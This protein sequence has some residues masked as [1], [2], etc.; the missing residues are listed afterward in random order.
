MTEAITSNSMIPA[1]PGI[2]AAQIAAGAQVIAP[3]V[4]VTPPI[5]AP[6][7]TPVPAV[8]AYDFWGGVEQ[9]GEPEQIPAQPAGAPVAPVAPGVSPTAGQPTVP[10]ATALTPE[11]HAAI[12]E[13]D[14]KGAPVAVPA[15]AQ[16]PQQVDGLMQQTIAHLAQTEYAM[17]K[18]VA[19]KLVSNPEEVYPTLA[20]TMHVRLASQIGQAV[21]TLLPSIVEKI[22]SAKLEANRLENDFFRLYPLL[23]DPR[24][25]SVVA[26]SLSM[27]RQA[28]PQ[29]P[30]EQ[31]M[32]D[33]ASL[34][35]LKLRIAPQGVAPAQVVVP[36]APLSPA[37]IPVQQPL[38]APVAPLA[39]VPF[40]PAAG[41]GG[42]LPNLAPGL[43]NEFEALALDQNW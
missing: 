18:E 27:A 37:P 7:T 12:I 34:A 25:R 10:V 21:S 32:N 1:N 38:V 6:V 28:N 33:G 3:T 24:F 29:A 40:Q 42:A 31:V 5:V 9:R 17:P 8:E 16:A 41:G 36:G 35:A 2:A 13:A 11:Q 39:V 14:A 15:P 43:E 20:A 22:V 4:T 19:D 26:Q 23:A 30:R